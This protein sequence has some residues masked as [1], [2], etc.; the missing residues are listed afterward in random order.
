MFSSFT[1]LGR[2][3]R[4]LRPDANPVRRRL[5]PAVRGRVPPGG[6][7]R[8]NRTGHLPA[9]LV[10]PAGNRSEP[11]AGESTGGR[12]RDASLARPRR[13]GRIRSVRGETLCRAG[14]DTAPGTT[15]RGQTGALFHL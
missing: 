5:L 1:P 12:A 2:P 14:A 9:G 6:H 15:G 3:R 8:P 11:N 13:T 7:H 4:G 10:R